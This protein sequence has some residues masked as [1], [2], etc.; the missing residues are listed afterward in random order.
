MNV[1]SNFKNFLFFI[2]KTH[3]TISLNMLARKLWAT[4]SQKTWKLTE[5]FSGPMEWSL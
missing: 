2:L 4:N 3:I 5:T 1:A